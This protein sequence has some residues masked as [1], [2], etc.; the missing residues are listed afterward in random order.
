MTNI[1]DRL[2]DRMRGAVLA[3]ALGDAFGAPYEGGVAERLLWRILGRQSGK[4]RWT[5]DT[6]MSVDVIESLL[7]CKK[8][9]QNDLARRFARSYRWSR[10]YGPGAA[11]LLKRIRQGESWQIAN[12]IV[13]PDGSFG[14]GGAMRAAPIGLFYGA[15]RERRL[16]RAVRDATIVTH[17]HPIGQDGAVVIALTTA[18]VCQDH[19]VQEILKRLRLYIQT[20]DLQ[21]RLAV[22]EKLLRADHLVLPNQ[23]ASELGNS[24]RAKDSCVTAFSIGL[25][26]REA[27]FSELLAY[28]RAVGGDTDTIG[29]MAGAIWGAACGYRQLPEDLLNQLEQ[30]EYLEELAHRFA[31]AVVRR[32]R[33]GLLPRQSNRIG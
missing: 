6:Q 8:V 31:D 1:N 18:L 11:K 14:N 3:S 24:I 22:A 25:A 2:H 17:A 4:R 28:V 9:E 5:D 7:A 32:T 30:R 29:A 33:L 15:E 23:V 19:P 13:Y 27:P 21:N 10:G 12:R 26:L 16:V 20:I